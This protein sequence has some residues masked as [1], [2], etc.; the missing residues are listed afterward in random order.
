ML[1]ERRRRQQA[2]AQLLLGG[3]WHALQIVDGADLLG[4]QA[5]GGELAAVERRVRPQVVDLTAQARVLQLA[6]RRVV[7]RFHRREER[8]AAH[9]GRGGADVVDH[10]VRPGR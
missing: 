6:Q 9:G 2:V 7:E 5:G 1:A 4:L 8:L 3:E 10:G